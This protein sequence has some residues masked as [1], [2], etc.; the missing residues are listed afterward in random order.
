VLGQGGRAYVVCEK[1]TEMKKIEVPLF[2]ATPR[3]GRPIKYDFTPFLRRT[4]EFVVFAGVPWSDYESFKN[5][6]Y[7]WRKENNVK[8]RYEYDYR[9]PFED[10]PS[11]I[12]IWRIK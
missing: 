11:C 3:R 2:P 6:F 8:G 1:E 4:V 5:A 7:T 9:E 12:T 10:T